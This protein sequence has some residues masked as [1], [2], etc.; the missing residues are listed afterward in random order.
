VERELR[1]LGQRAQQDQ[2]QRQRVQRVRAHLSPEASTGV[3]VVAADDVAQHQHAG[4]QRQPAVPVTASA[5]RAPRG[6]RLAVVPVA[7]QQERED[8]GQLPEHHQLQ[9]VARQHHAQHRRP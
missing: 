5:M 1:A 2:H 7:D 3:E 4:Q 6:H 8:A 9:Q